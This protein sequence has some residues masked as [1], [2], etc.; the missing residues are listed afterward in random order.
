MARNL[1]ALL[2]GIDKYDR[3]SRV[4]HLRGC[5]N[6]I[7]GMQDYLEGRVAS[8]EFDLHLRVL[9][10]EES[11]RQ[12]IID[13]FQQHL[14]QA[15]ADDVALF[16]Y[17][18]HGAQADAPEAF[19][20]VSPDRLMETLVCYDSRVDDDHWDLA[21]K[22]LAQLIAEVD[23]KKPHIVA[24]LDC[25]HSGSG[26]REAEEPAVLSRKAP[27]DKRSR[28][29]ESF[30]I[31]PA[32][33]RF[34]ETSSPGTTRSVSS[35]PIAMKLPVGRHVVLSA[36]SDIEEAKEYLGAG[37]PRGTFSYF[38]QESLAKASGGLSYRDLFKRTNALVRT[39]VGAQSPQLEATHSEDLAQPFLGGAIAPSVPYY[40]VTR[41]KEHGW[42]IDGGAIHGLQAP[43]GDSGDAQ[44]T[45]L[46]LFPFDASPEQLKA[47]ADSLG[48]V[49]ITE[50]LPQLSKVAGDALTDE[51]DTFKAV[52]VSSPLPPLKVYLEGYAASDQA[53]VESLKTAIATVGP[54][55]APSFYVRTIDSL[56]G[57]A[58]RV[59]AKDNTYLITSPV[60][61]R[62]LVTPV[63][64]YEAASALK[65]A[66]NLEHI[67]RWKTIA[68]LDSPAS[69][70]I[71]GAIEPKIYTG[72]EASKDASSEITDSQIRL[73]YSYNR[74]KQAWVPPR[75]RIKLHNTSDKT[76]YCAL[77]Y[78]TERFKAEA[79]KPDAVGSLVRLD[80]GQELWFANGA[81]LNGTVADDLWKSGVTECQDIL[82]LIACT[83]EFDPML[84]NL[85]ELGSPVS[86]TRSVGAGGGS[87]NRL[88]Q[89]VNTRDISFADDAPD[90]DDWV[91]NQVT[92]TFVRPRL[93]TPLNQAETISLGANV[94]VLPHGE[95]GANARLTTV[96]QSTRDLGSAILPPILQNETEAFQFTSSR[97]SDPGL[98]AL[99]LNNVK[100]PES[101]TPENPLRL[102]ADMPLGEGEYL[103][104]VA[105]DGEFYLPLGYGQAKD[106]KTEIVIERL[107]E[108]VTEGN[109]SIHGSIRIFFQ[110]VAANKLGDD[111]S[112][113]LGLDFK[114][115]LLAVAQLETA[116]KPGGKVTYLRDAEAVKEK[117]AQAKNIAL[118]IHGIFG[119]TASMLP[120]MNTAV[121]AIEDS[122]RPIGE[123]YDLV[124]AFDYEN[125]NTTIDQNARSLKS[126]LADI[127]LGTGHD[128][129]LHII[130]HSMGGLVSR[131]FIE[132][133]GGNEVVNHL[134]MLGT[135]NA[136]SPWP[137]VQ[138]G[139]TAAVSYAINGLSLVA[140]PLMVL[141][142]LLKRIETLDLSLDQMQP[143]SD[144][145]KEIAQSPDPGIP[146]TLVVGNTSLIEV[147]ES[148]GLKEKILHRLG[149]VVE[150]PFF[151][152][153]ND[154]A[155][156]VE[157]ITAIP[158][159]RSLEPKAL[160]VACNH[161]EYF[162]NPIGLASL[163]EAVLGTGIV[164]SGGASEATSGAAEATPEASAVETDAPTTSVGSRSIGDTPVEADSNKPSVT[165][166]SAA[167]AA[168]AAAAAA[169]SA[170]T[171]SEPATAAASTASTTAADGP[172]LPGFQPLPA[173]QPVASAPSAPTESPY[174]DEPSPFIPEGSQKSVVPNPWIWVVVA[175]LVVGVCLWGWS[176]LKQPTPSDS[177]PESSEVDPEG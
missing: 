111:L 138:A 57:A 98:S 161:L 16:Y 104:P 131:W 144:F 135:P 155:V 147:D 136:G 61:N 105:Y 66:Q 69:S 56:E 67:A 100:H 26:T 97:S 124:L 59:L 166:T 102:E 46:A 7:Q 120:S 96:P 28:P 35:A 1:Y 150:M 160:P 47:A 22:E 6:D 29:L 90:Y 152:Q 42:I 109:R 119:D 60:D 54:M 129:T 162:T 94:R 4:P 21:D 168:A 85:G 32:E 80:P 9:K 175:A 116:G 170:A 101:V 156:L 126:R 115:P 91:A 74:T 146:Y 143:E 173:A 39:N 20:P 8:D 164:P 83:D 10:N 19:W 125:L 145:L 11:T 79:I 114:Y 44:T 71:Q 14:T 174:D 63:K 51:A 5:V 34:L 159:G 92:F 50:V 87:L 153:P 108:P 75:F 148:A 157:S 122:T 95:L 53:G 142:G 88:M 118:Y 52:M 99:E 167:S 130:A 43:V 169:A 89:R 31:S 154:I 149:K 58:F 117:V 2:V 172:Q 110:K 17:A 76:L 13:G 103:L 3:R 163:S 64:G 36:C 139:I 23:R 77:F 33:A 113:T 86:G 38:L 70:Q 171:S 73:E 128:K 93:T 68:E 30:I 123:L 107:T 65:V 24:V 133:E 177:L 45:T 37:E 137:Q 134:I 12:G 62:P 127:G 15:G 81:A 165:T 40:T 55:S 18:G 49:K 78:L 41:H 176:Q 141:N 27:P 106:G 132:R 140:A 48:S 121:A 151:K 72:A 84:M 25:C 112:T 158:E 82:K